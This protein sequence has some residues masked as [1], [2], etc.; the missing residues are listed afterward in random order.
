MVTTIV[1][2]IVTGISL[3]L[4]LIVIIACSNA[5]ISQENRPHHH[6]NS[7]FQ[8]LFDVEPAS[9]KGAMFIL[10]RIWNS[11]FPPEI[12]EGHIIPEP[13]AIQ[14]YYT[15]EDQNSLTWLGHSTFLLKLEGKTIL[16]DPFLLE[17]ASPVSFV[18][19]LARFAPPGISIKNLPPIDIIL[20]SHNHYDHLDLH[21]LDALP[22][23]QKTQVFVPLGLKTAVT[24]LGYKNIHEKDWYQKVSFN[25]LDITALPAVHDSGRGLHDKNETLWA[26]WAITSN[27]KNYYFAG[28]TGYSPLFKEIGNKFGSF[29][30]AIVPIGAYAPRELM[31]MSHV[32]PEE[33]IAIGK[34]VNAKTVVGGHWGTIDLSEEPL[35]EPPIRFLASAKNEGYDENNSWIMKIGES[36]VIN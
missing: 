17:R 27:S 13:D 12:P 23:K 16:T 15:L 5:S 21:T 2:Q 19:G 33:A 3:G 29:D 20:I 25:G 34:D 26:S 14:T 6:T 36:R 28:D 18:G 30:L 8:N 22:N 10:Q 32:T 1:K 4:L 35:W 7:G 9:S 31:W 24:E 11:T